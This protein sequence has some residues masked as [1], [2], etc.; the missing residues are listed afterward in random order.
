MWDR[1]EHNEF[2]DTVTE[3]LARLFPEKPPR[4]LPRTPY[5]YNDPAVIARDL[6][7]GGFTSTPVIDTVSA[8]SR[9]ASPRF[10]AIGFCQGTP[11]RNEVD[12]L[13]G[14]R[15]EEATDVAAD[16]IAKKFGPAIVDGKIQAH[17]V[18]VAR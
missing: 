3:A 12:A 15:L 11:V 2:A 18:T 9:A 1:I 7:A 17:V 6:K 4:F 16:A 8:R 5:G 14:G 13:G 10:P